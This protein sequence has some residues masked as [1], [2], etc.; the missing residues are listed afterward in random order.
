MWVGPNFLSK[1]RIILNG[2]D[3]TGKSAEHGYCEWDVSKILRPKGNELV[4]EFEAPSAGRKFTGLLG[5]IHLYHRDFAARSF[6]LAKDGKTR[7]IYVPKEW[8]GKYRVFLYMEDAQ[9]KPPTGVSA[10]HRFMR[11]HHHNF[12]NVTDIDITSILRFGED[13]VLTLGHE[14]NDTRDYGRL[15]T[16]RLDLFEI[17]R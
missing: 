4:V 14:M 17:P 11:K 5:S 15:D 12:G 1:G 6:E 7:T 2:V 10:N 3:L 9:K 16:V 8:Q 13:N